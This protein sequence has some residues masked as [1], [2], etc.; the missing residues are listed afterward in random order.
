[1][2]T[3]DSTKTSSFFSFFL[4]GGGG[5]I[6]EIFLTFG[7]GKGALTPQL[8]KS[9][10][11]KRVRW[12]PTQHCTVPTETFKPTATSNLTASQLK[13]QFICE[14]LVCC[15]FCGGFCGKYLLARCGVYF[16]S[17]WIG[18]LATRDRGIRSCAGHRRSRRIRT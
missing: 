5:V 7:G 18:L 13:E 9:G 4:G 17:A 12:M 10:V 14:C 11:D 16:C 8:D 15:T 3:Q 1:M 2:G 6:S